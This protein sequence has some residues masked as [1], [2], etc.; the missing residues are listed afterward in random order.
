MLLDNR[1]AIIILS[2]LLCCAVNASLISAQA[3]ILSNTQPVYTLYIF[4][5]ANVFFSAFLKKFHLYR[6]KFAYFASGVVFLFVALSLGLTVHIFSDF[7]F[8]LSWLFLFAFANRLFPW[9]ISEMA[10]K[11][12]DPARAQSAFSY[13]ATCDEIGTMLAVVLLKS[14]GDKLT[15]H[16]TLT[17]VA[18]LFLAVL[19]VMVFQFFPKRNLEVQFSKKSV[20]APFIEGKLLKT[21]TL[22]FLALSIGLGAFK[23][24]E[25]YLTKVVLKENLSSYEAIRSTVSNY[26]IV[27]SI[28]TIMINAPMTRLIRKTRLSPV[29]LIWIQTSSLLVMASL[30][31]VHPAF[32][33]FLAFEVMRRVVQNCFYTP[34]NQMILSSFIGEIRNRLRSS[35][36]FYYYT[37][38]GLVLSLLFSVT[39]K[40][41]YPHQEKLILGLILIFLALS[42]L[43]NQK[44]GNA[45]TELMYAFVR[46]GH[47]TA[48]I[49]ALNLLSFLRPKD[50]GEE[51]TKLLTLSPKK[52]IRKTI[53]LGLGYEGKDSSLSAVLG[54]FQSD[55]EEIQIAVLDAL[56][57]AHHYKATQFLMKILM[58]QEKP[59]SLRVRMNA[60]KI[61]AGLYG[62]QVIPFLLNG[63]EDPDPR[64]VANTLETLS[65]YKDKNL[66]PYFRKF[67]KSEN[68]RV[69]G[70]ALLGLSYFKTTRKEYFQAF[71]EIL[72]G[73][74]L[75]MISSI[76]YVIGMVRDS[77]FKGEIVALKNS[78]IGKEAP[79]RGSLAWALTR[80]GDPRGFDLMG[81][82]LFQPYQ[83]GQSNPALH[84]LSQLN[85]ET[86]FDLIKYLVSNYKYT[87]EA[88]FHLGNHLKNSMYDFHEEIEY[89]QILSQPA[90][91]NRPSEKESA[92][93]N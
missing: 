68:P 53:I 55:K 66:I 63:L 18:I 35:Y 56:K 48:S 38:V 16:Q 7:W 26:T 93:G 21:F 9:M 82:M 92:D 57:V 32:Y 85:L 37:V 71:E 69:R 64:I 25:D 47:K 13:L 17:G 51:M 52:L 6:F 36:N 43:T 33:F 46:T 50:Y 24:A 81:E 75:K 91:A 42:F 61:V 12:L 29:L 74:D 76:L 54:E 27:A 83:E 89:L 40:L 70:N 73:G 86:R 19:A 58:A 14:Q 88:L 34:A 90:K 41:S 65:I 80:F 44:M 28:L 87:P 78:P 15:T 3:F 30:C 5:V 72:K 22:A 84:F 11:H 4:L 23:V 39:Q 8:G 31:F 77:H 20:K 1:I 49:I 62:R 59:K 2:I 60:T 45:L 10:I 79:I 67:S